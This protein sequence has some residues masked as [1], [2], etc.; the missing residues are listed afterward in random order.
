MSHE[1]NNTKPENNR[2]DY[3]QNFTVEQRQIEAYE[4]DIK[5][6]KN[7]DIAKRLD[8]SLST[9]E[10][11]LKKIKSETITTLKKIGKSGLLDA[12]HDASTQLDLVLDE[13]WQLSEKEKDPQIKRKLLESITHI[14]C[15]KVDLWKNSP[16]LPKTSH[17]KIQQMMDP[18][19]L[20]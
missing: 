11:D 8:V 14:A 5:G 19:G 17:E 12:F 18:L 13:L 1:T 10:K 15:R 6:Y 3:E 16:E 2:K 20:D 9:I 4:L 7:K